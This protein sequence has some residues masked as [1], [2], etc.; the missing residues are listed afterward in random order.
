MSSRAAINSRTSAVA[1]VLIFALSRYAF[2]TIEYWSRFGSGWISNQGEMLTP[3]GTSLSDDHGNTIS[4]FGSGWITNS[5]TTIS[6]FGNALIDDHGNSL[7]PF[8]SNWITN[9]G[10][11]IGPFGNGFFIDAN[12]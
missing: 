5:G 6:P 4:P 9:G 8:G 2:A 11:T 10:T 1:I 12:S 7:M 3:F